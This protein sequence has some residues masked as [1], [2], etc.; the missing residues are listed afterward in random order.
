MKQ[1]AD[2]GGELTASRPNGETTEA[3][4]EVFSTDN[5]EDIETARQ[6]LAEAEIEYFVRDLGGGAF[7][8]HMGAEHACRIAVS[9]TQLQV[10]HNVI[11]EAIE[12]GAITS[13]G[14]LLA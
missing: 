9:A 5:R 2:C 1:C 4:V 3:F 14:A 7:P 13:S 11:R 8:V 10:A 12:D 6:V